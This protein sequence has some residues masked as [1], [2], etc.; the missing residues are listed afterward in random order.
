MTFYTRE[1]N[2]QY[3]QLKAITLFCCLT[4]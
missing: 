2:L 4:H 1:Q 3:L